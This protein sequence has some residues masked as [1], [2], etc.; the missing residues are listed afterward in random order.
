MEGKMPT[1]MDHLGESDI[2]AMVRLIGK[3]AGSKSDVLVREQSRFCQAAW[4][5]PVGA[6]GW[7]VVRNARAGTMFLCAADCFMAGLRRSSLP[8]G[9]SQR[10][11]QEP[12]LPEHEK[13]NEISLPAS[14]CGSFPR[15][16]LVPD[17]MW[18]SHPTRCT[19]S[20][21][22]KRASMTFSIR[23]IRFGE[24]SFVNAI[25]LYRHVGR[26]RFSARDRR[27]VHIVLSEVSWL[28]YAGLPGDFGKS[29]PELSPRRRTVLVLLINGMS[30]KEI[31][32][33]LGISQ[34]TARDH[35]EAVYA[36]PW[37][38]FAGRSGPPFFVGD[39][40]DAT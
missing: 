9:P 19:G 37:C 36:A 13:C 17:K 21:A 20:I 40:N 11:R 16:Q 10:R 26:P 3:A 2:R 5:A 1:E 25:S 31:A 8:P 4:L 32:Q 22:S 27:I 29:V 33:A 34:N 6:D 39:G 23:F 18:Y 28:H 15:E 38:C 24:P 35:I 7:S 14:S 30:R 12:G